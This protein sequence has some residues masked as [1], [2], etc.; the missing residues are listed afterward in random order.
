MQQREHELHLRRL[1][2]IKGSYRSFDNKRPHTPVFLAA[3]YKRQVQEQER[4]DQIV[5]ENNLLLRKM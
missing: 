3:N 1:N 4:E 2:K 5:R